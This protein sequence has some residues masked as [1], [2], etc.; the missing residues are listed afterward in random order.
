MASSAVEAAVEIPEF[1]E[2]RL[3]AAAMM[4]DRSMGWMLSFRMGS[5]C[6]RDSSAHWFTFLLES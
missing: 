6:A 5:I 4:R 1:L 3:S 2:L